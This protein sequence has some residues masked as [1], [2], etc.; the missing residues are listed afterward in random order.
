[1]GTEPPPQTGPQA[2]VVR[3][4]DGHQ[5][6]LVKAGPGVTVASLIA[7][8]GLE[9]RPGAP[10]LLASSGTATLEGDALSRTQ[11]VFASAVARAAALAKP[12]IIDGGVARGISIVT[13]STRAEAPDT[14]PVLIGVTPAASTDDA[15]ATSAAGM[16]LERNHTHFVQSDAGQR[17]S[18]T[19]L[20][21]ALGSALAGSGPAVMVLAGGEDVA[22]AEALLA[23]E[24][25]WPIHV[26]AGTGGL[27]D[28]IATEWQKRHAPRA[29]WSPPAPAL[30]AIADDDLRRIVADGQIRV[31]GAGEPSQFAR[32]IA[33]DLQDEPALKDVWKLFAGYDERAGHARKV[34]ER[35]QNAILLLGVVATLVALLASATKYVPLH[36]LAVAAPIVVSSVIA[37]ANRRAAGKRWVV[38][39]AAAESMKAEIYRYRTRTGLYADDKLPNEDPAGRP[40][41]LAD[42][43]SRLDGAL[44]ATEASN[45]DLGE[46]T[47]PLPPEMFGA[48]QRDDGLSTLDPAAYLR[49]R[50]GDQASYF[51]GRV[52]TLDRRREWLQALGVGAGGAGAIVAAAGAAVWVGLTTA[53][54]GAA[55]SYLGYLQVDNT[56]VTY[57][58]ARAKIRLLELEWKAHA[59]ATDQDAFTQLV[60]EGEAVL[61]LELSGW[62]RQMTQAVDRL[63]S[64]QHQAPRSGGARSRRAT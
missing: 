53:I 31:F 44:M 10:V 48:S 35:F 26:I 58:Q 18:E 17:D 32:Q 12:T 29:R 40:Q 38:I 9:H 30:S 5:A 14:I 64:E 27:A 33:W 59:G 42:R 6:T 41:A 7:A 2:T 23:V 52:K 55:L 56:I 20:L 1:M 24:R 47:G 22:K 25:Q 61:G 54:S 62:V 36:W 51:E 37:L 15:Q 19:D 8:L 11:G 39:R 43:I 3:F 63:Q 28:M 50:L 21:F 16:P 45:A 46:Y 49:F 60:T 57:N 4:D 34:Y 13:G